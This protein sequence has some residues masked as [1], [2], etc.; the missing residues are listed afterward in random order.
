MRGNVLQEGNGKGSIDGLLLK[1]AL[2]WNALLE[3][4]K[5]EG[6]PKSKTVA[7]GRPKKRD[8]GRWS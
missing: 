2:T 4:R 3:T 7:G 8:K 6:F 1:E 5:G